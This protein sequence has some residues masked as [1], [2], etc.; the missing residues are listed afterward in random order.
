MQV[1]YRRFGGI[2]GM[3]CVERVGTGPTGCGRPRQSAGYTGGRLPRS[4]LALSLVSGLP[5]LT[6]RRGP[7][8]RTTHEKY[9]TVGGSPPD[10]PRVRGGESVTTRAPS[11][12]RGPAVRTAS[13]LRCG[14]TSMHD[15]RQPEQ[16]S[17]PPRPS[18]ATGKGAGKDDDSSHYEPACAESK[19]RRI[20]DGWNTT[21]RAH[22]QKWP[23]TLQCHPSTV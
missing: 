5:R 13:G 15:P 16:F 17:E 22:S 3:Y 4:E 23:Q 1:A 21:A 14:W 2:R 11:H 9:S 20:H 6:T 8:W 7:A 18:S 10:A 12:T 19:W